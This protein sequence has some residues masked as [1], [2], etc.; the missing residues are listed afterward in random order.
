MLVFVTEV[1]HSVCKN[2]K[3]LYVHYPVNLPNF[4]ERS[5]AWHAPFSDVTLSL[6]LKLADKKPDEVLFHGPAVDISKF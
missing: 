6:T 3:D 5:Y 2:G 1:Y 4:T